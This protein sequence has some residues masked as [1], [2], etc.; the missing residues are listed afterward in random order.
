MAMVYNCSGGETISYNL[1]Y[2]IWGKLFGHGL[3]M[4]CPGIQGICLI[5]NF[6]HVVLLTKRHL[7]F[8]RRTEKRK[9]AI[10]VQSGPVFSNA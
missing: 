4:L 8:K 5:L 9:E 3:I 2:N 1:L 7:S 10:E 6:F